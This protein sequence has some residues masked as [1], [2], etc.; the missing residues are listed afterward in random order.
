MSCTVGREDFLLDYQGREGRAKR[1]LP[2]SFFLVSSLHFIHLY[3]QYFVGISSN[4]QVL[5][6]IQIFEKPFTAFVAEIFCENHF[7]F[8]DLWLLSTK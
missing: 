1:I 5:V 8:R 3:L 4:S 2:F 7:N 6:N